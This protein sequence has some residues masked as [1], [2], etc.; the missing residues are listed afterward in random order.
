MKYV[1]ILS[2]RMITLFQITV[3]LPWLFNVYLKNY[4][5]TVERIIKDLLQTSVYY[6][7]NPPLPVT[8]LI[9]IRS[10]VKLLTPMCVWFCYFY[11]FVYVYVCLEKSVYTFS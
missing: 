9:A 10:G 11:V 3:I 8:H 1:I 7:W 6:N 2:D 4:N 5:K